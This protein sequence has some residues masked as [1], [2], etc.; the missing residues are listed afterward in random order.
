MNAYMPWAILCGAGLG[1]GLWIIMANLPGWRKM[2]FAERIAPHVRV[3]VRSSRM[4]EDSWHSES[5][6][7]ALGQLAAPLLQQIKKIASVHSPTADTVRRRLHA[8]G[9]EISV[10]DYRSQEIVYA[11]VGLVGGSAL[12]V[13]GAIQYQLSLVSAAL[14]VVGC[15]ILG[16]A[17]RGWWLGEQVSRRARKVLTQFPTVAEVLALTVGAGESTT[18]AIERI[19]RSCHGVIGDEFTKTL[20]DIHAGTPMVQAMQ[21][22]SDRMQVGAMTRFVDAIVVATE[23]G[24]PLAQVLRDQAQDVR[25]A[26]KREL[27]EVAGKRE[28]S[29]LVPVVFG[30]LP[31]TIVFA[32]FPGLALLEMSY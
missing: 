10:V 16:Y 11:L 29:M 14:L 25:D 23:R 30:I 12:V 7:S 31:L 2:A 21:H 9:L 17:L 32:I 3:G 1:L 13:F 28:I 8:A 22:M 24:T 20:N 18:G 6:H 26:S 4:L 19:S 5:G 27:M 15:G